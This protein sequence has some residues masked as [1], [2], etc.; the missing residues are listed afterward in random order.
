MTS[1]LN[2]S[3]QHF[4]A[5]SREMWSAR[6]SQAESLY[7]SGLLNVEDF[8][9]VRGI[10]MTNVVTLVHADVHRRGINKWFC[11]TVQRDVR[12]YISLWIC[13]S[14]SVTSYLVSDRKTLIL[15]CLRLHI[16]KKYCLAHK[17][18]ALSFNIGFYQKHL[19]HVTK[20]EA[21]TD[22]WEANKHSKQK[23]WYFYFIVLCSCWIPCRWVTG[24]MTD[25]TWAPSLV[26]IIQVLLAAQD[27][28]AEYWIDLYLC[29]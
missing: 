3:C 18:C 1:I 25:F 16:V 10:F 21:K 11:Q 15:F 23:S 20:V 12:L 19:R 5:I 7:L 29:L 6:W 27:T 2:P 9:S 8:F 17:S 13:T 24:K 28:G 14:S 26:V 4:H 22:L